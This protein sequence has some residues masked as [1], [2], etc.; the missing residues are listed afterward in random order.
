MVMCTVSSGN[1]SNKSNRQKRMMSRHVV[2]EVIF[3]NLTL[4]AQCEPPSVGLWK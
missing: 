2:A 4:C 1:S 3:P